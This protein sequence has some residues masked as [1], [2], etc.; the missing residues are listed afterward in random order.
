[1]PWLTLVCRLITRSYCQIE[2]HTRLSCRPEFICRMDGE[3]RKRH[4]WECRRR[5]LVC[6]FTRPGCKRCSA[7]GTACPG[8]SDVKPPRLRWLQPG[9]VKSRKVQKFKP[10]PKSDE[11]TETNNNS[12]STPTESASTGEVAEGVCYPGTTAIPRRFEPR[13]EICAL[14][15]AV[16]YFN[17][18]IYQDLIPVQGLGPNSA[19][20]TI[21]PS[22][23][24]GGIVFPDYVRLSLVC[25]TLSHRVNRT[26][27][28][29]DTYEQSGL[30]AE[31]FYRYR[32]IIIRSLNEDI[33]VESKRTS[34][35]VLAGII[36]LLLADAQQGPS[37]HWRIHLEGVHRLIT[38][39]GGIHFLA[40][41]ES[42]EA[43]L[44][45]FVS[46]AV[47]GNTTSQA[48]DLV[49][50]PWHFSELD[51][52]LSQY[53]SKLFPPQMCPPLLFAEIIRIN[54]LRHM[55]ATIIT[56]RPKIAETITH[57]H[58][59]DESEL[60]QEAYGILSRI[61]TFHPAEWVSL[62]PPSA[63]HDWMLL[64]EIYQSAVAI[65]CISSLQS[66]SILPLAEPLR[67]SCAAHA[68]RLHG[69]LVEALA[70]PRIKRFMLWPLVMLGM[71]LEAVYSITKVHGFV[72]EELVELSRHLGS[73]A[74]LT[75]KGMLERFWASGGGVGMSWD[76]CFDQPYVFATQIAVDISRI[77]PPT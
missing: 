47:I 27:S 69:F 17:T 76:E 33:N 72:A 42:L 40:R 22:Q 71:S 11:K 41:L 59:E 53:G 54:Y 18:C 65:Y 25:M 23:L 68:E 57:S 51:F 67:S 5:C 14:A 1:M 31:T 75:A 46:V 36:S 26:R 29:H 35:A 49:M 44:L 28:D 52:I 7:S 10:G 48:T 13:T 39:R 77:S 73:Y 70:S 24:E 56:T 8:Y 6:D 30:L 43:L 9:K 32:G 12:S 74:P 63:K 4:C 38:L 3:D 34:D 21:S 20:Y 37:P 2:L 19:I 50:A 45:C 15:Q 16:G 58:E 55:W 61:Q 64:G 66:L 60:R 62:K